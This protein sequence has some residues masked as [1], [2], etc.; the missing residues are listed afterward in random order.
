MRHNDKTWLFT[1]IMLTIINRWEIIR[2]IFL[3]SS[4]ITKVDFVSTDFAT[5]CV[6][7]KLVLY[8]GR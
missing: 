4:M 8:G 3:S 5:H 1:D 7:D 6:Y 2:L